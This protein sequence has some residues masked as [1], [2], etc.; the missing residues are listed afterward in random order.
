M[1]ETLAPSSSEP[2]ISGSLK[3][4]HSLSVAEKKPANLSWKSPVWLIVI[5]SVVAHIG[6]WLLLPNPIR[7]NLEIANSL[8]VSAIPVVTLPPEVLLRANRSPQQLPSLNLNQ[9]TQQSIPQPSANPSFLPPP[10]LSV[11]PQEQLRNSNLRSIPN[12][13]NLSSNLPIDNGK[14][15]NQGNLN[16]PTR[17]SNIRPEIT[18]TPPKIINNSNPNSSNLTNNTTPKNPDPSSKVDPVT[19]YSYRASDLIA[20]KKLA[21]SDLGGVVSQYGANNVVQ[22]QIA[23]PDTPVAPDKREPIDWID[24]D[25]QA[26]GGITGT[27]A[28]VL[29]VGPDGRVEQEPMVIEST[30]SKLEQVA[31]QTI[32]GYY[33]K[34][35][36]IESGRYRLVRIQYKV[37]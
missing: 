29:V 37:L 4:W 23:S 27:V 3:F 34:F 9:N 7:R 24:I 5:G 10:L 2:E 26:L 20:A 18:T 35:Q 31:R 11:L 19:G 28:F 30:N 32:K 14:N 17:A 36:P 25:K 8:K 15:S 33:N 21:S 12:L 16:F 22:R 13:N 6:F 1:S